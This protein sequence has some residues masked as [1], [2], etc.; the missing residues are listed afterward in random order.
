MKI[1][2]EKLNQSEKLNIPNTENYKHPKGFFGFFEPKD[3]YNKL[4]GYGPCDENFKLTW[5]HKE[6]II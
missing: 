1:N 2:M 6:Y 4:V 5:I 3:G